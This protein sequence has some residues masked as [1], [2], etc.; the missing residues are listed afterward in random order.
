MSKPVEVRDGIC[1]MCTTACPTKIHVRDGRAVKI[2]IADP[3]VAHCP[4][5][6]AQ[7]C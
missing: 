7:L 3:K 5:W 2:D 4:R 6:K 1:Y